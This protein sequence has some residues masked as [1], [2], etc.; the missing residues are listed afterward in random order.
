[1][2]RSVPHFRQ[3]VKAASNAAIPSRPQF[4]FRVLI[5]ATALSHI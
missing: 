5:A 2:G 3:A 4:W 1:V